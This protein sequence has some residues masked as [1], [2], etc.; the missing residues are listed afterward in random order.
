MGVMKTALFRSAACAI[1]TAGMGGGCML[2]FLLMVGATCAAAPENTGAPADHVSIAGISGPLSD[3][4]ITDDGLL[5][6]GDSR[7][8][9]PLQQHLS[10][11][12]AQNGAPG[13]E[14]SPA[15][16]DDTAAADGSGKPNPPRKWQTVLPI[17]GEEAEAQGHVLPRAFGLMPGFYHGRR[18]ISVSDSQVT[19]KRMTF[20]ADRLTDIKVKSRELNWS[21]RLD[22]W[23]FP[24]LNIYGLIG[25]TRED[26]YAGISLTPLNQLRRLVGKR[27]RDLLDLHMELTGATYGA[28]FTLVGG[29]K[30]FFATYDSNYTISALRGDLPFDNTLSPDVKALLNSIR[31]GLRSRIAG[32]NVATWI[33]GTYW[34]TTNTIKG[35]PRVPIIGKVRFRVREKTSNPWSAHV[36][37]NVEM[38]ESFQL[39]L[40]IGSNFSGLFAVAPTLMYRF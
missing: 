32:C 1:K 3:G 13:T 39:V 12:L 19:I 30:N 17:L 7:A 14:R 23:L 2:M 4:G 25:Y 10:G 20:P 36:G 5:H 15:P 24:F 29:Y 18:H 38:S 28:G 31:V 22:A 35:T 37:T 6:L 34:D 27:P 26:A 9:D 8:A 11:L 16:A 21:L 40:D 33:G